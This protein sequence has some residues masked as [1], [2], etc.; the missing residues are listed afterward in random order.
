MEKLNVGTKLNNGA[1]VMVYDE[2]SNRMLC[3]WNGK[4]VVWNHVGNK[5]AEFGHYFEDN[6]KKAVEAFGY[7]MGFTYWEEV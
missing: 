1:T 5:N 2:V 4:Y 7:N 3:D 6:L